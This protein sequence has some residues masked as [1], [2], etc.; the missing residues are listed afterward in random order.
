MQYI[1]INNLS[2]QFDGTDNTDITK[3]ALEAIELINLSLQRDP[4]GLGA[5]IV[6]VPN[7]ITVQ[8]EGSDACV[9]VDWLGL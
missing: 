2:I 7:E 8:V 3:Q 4:Y 9:G 6:F 1:T 5:Q